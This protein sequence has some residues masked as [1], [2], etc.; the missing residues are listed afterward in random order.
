MK[1]K[2]HLLVVS[3]AVPLMLACQFIQPSMNAD[4]PTQTQ[5]TPSQPTAILIPSE[6]S[7]QEDNKNSPS[8][9]F[10]DAGYF[11]TDDAYNVAHNENGS[12]EFYTDLSFDEIEDYYRQ[13]LPLHGYSE[14]FID[15]PR[16][17]EG[18]E[19]MFFEGNPNRRIL[20]VMVCIIFQ[21]EEHWV[22][23]GLVDK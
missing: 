6:V 5:E 12:L 1:T 13:E 20:I 3:I 15:G 17:V 23:V 22:S 7:T 10:L 8:T 16:P 2:Q 21:T 14:I 18:C 11:L 19:Q 9:E 4:V